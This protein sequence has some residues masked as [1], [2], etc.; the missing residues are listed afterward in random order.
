MRMVEGPDKTPEALITEAVPP[1]GLQVQK[2]L[3]VILQASKLKRVFLKRTEPQH[4]L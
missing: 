2:Q 1:S 3:S 4:Y